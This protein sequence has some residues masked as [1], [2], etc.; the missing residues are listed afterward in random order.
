MTQNGRSNNNGDTTR[1]V[2]GKPLLYHVSLHAILST[3][4]P[5]GVFYPL[6]MGELRPGEMLSDFSKFTQVTAQ[7]VPAQGRSQG[8]AGTQPGWIRTKD[9][10]SC[11]ENR[12]FNLLRQ[13]GSSPRTEKK[14]QTLLLTLPKRLLCILSF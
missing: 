7:P 6:Q 3:P 8:P 12:S 9:R 4:P 13:V 10:V 1:C 11:R 5:R 14:N 2:H